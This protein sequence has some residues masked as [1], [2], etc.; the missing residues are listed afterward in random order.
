[1]LTRLNGSLGTFSIINTLFN[2]DFEETWTVICS[3][4]RENEGVWVT[5]DLRIDDK[6]GAILSYDTSPKGIQRDRL[7]RDHPL[8]LN[9]L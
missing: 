1:M 5:A 7:F 6:S 2:F 9:N 8:N 3:F 4:K